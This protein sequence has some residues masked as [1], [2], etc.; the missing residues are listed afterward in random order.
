MEV[1]TQVIVTFSIISFAY[2]FHMFEP[3]FRARNVKMI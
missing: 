2:D 1:G 3:R